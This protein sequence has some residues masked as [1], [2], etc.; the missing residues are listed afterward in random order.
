MDGWIDRK[1]ERLNDITM[2]NYAHSLLKREASKK[3]I[4]HA[5]SRHHHLSYPV[6][7]RT[8]R[9]RRREL[10]EK[11]KAVNEITQHL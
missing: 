10:N 9:E 5:S 6:Y 3:V 8:E 1:K 11:K 2:K 7:S 4:T